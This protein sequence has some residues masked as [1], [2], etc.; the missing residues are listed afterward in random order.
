MTSLRRAHSPHR[1]DRPLDTT[2][3][4]F[5]ALGA[6]GAFRAVIVGLVEGPLTADLLREAVVHVQERHPLL[7]ARIV[8]GPVPRWFTPPESS[9][10]L[11]LARPGEDV[12]TVAEERLHETYDAEREPLWRVTLVPDSSRPDRN[13]LILAT[14]HAIADGRSVWRIMADLLESC[15]ALVKGSPL[16]PYLPR[17]P[18]LDEVVAKAP[19][20]AMFLHRL[21]RIRERLK[22]HR[23][24]PPDRLLPPIKERRTRILFRTVPAE[25]LRRLH[26]RAHQ[27]GIYMTGVFGAALLLAMA[28]FETHRPMKLS[29]P[30]CLRARASPPIDPNV[31]GCFVAGVETLHHIDSSTSFWPLAREVNRRLRGQLIRGAPEAGLIAARRGY[32]RIRQR[33]EENAAPRPSNAMPISNLGVLA[34]GDL[35]P[36]A[37]LESHGAVANHVH[38]DLCHLMCGTVRGQLSLGFAYVEPM[39][40]REKAIAI[41][42]RFEGRLVEMSLAA[43]PKN[44]PVE[45]GVQFGA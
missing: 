5:H 13:H 33:I 39:L 42:D 17:G 15:A 23:A 29:H 40:S 36:F 11:L 8:D 37:L 2:E 41:L 26:E 12:I 9:P 34:L 35:S 32:E 21:H 14:H 24:M 45:V 20:R 6:L 4:V 31:V 7:R 10:P 16:P 27:K 25:P 38:G 44:T 43:D 3:A 19:A 18:T 1:I 22:F 28:E 30:V